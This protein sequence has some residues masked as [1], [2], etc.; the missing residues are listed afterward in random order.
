VAVI[1]PSITHAG[2]TMG[3]PW[4]ARV[5]RGHREAGQHATELTERREQVGFDDRRVA[6]NTSYELRP[7]W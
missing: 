5:D 2:T 4:G 3:Q 6:A 7:R 1:P